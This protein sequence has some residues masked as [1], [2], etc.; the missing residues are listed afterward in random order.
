MTTPGSNEFGSV[1][2]TLKTEGKD[3]VV[4]DLKQVEQAAKQ[5]AEATNAAT[6]SPAS[7]AGSAANTA[8]KTAATAEATRTLASETERVA[9]N[10]RAAASAQEDFARQARDATK[11]IEFMQSMLGRVTAALSIGGAAIAGVWSLITKQQREAEAAFR[12]MSARA[13]E[14]EKITREIYGDNRNSLDRQLDALDRRQELE[15]KAY[16]RRDQAAKLEELRERYRDERAAIIRRAEDA[17]AIKAAQERARVYESELEKTQKAES[18]ARTEG[19]TEEE[20]VQDR[21]AQR[22]L[23]I[24]RKLSS[25]QDAMMRELL[26]RQLAAEEALAAKRLDSLAEKRAKEAEALAERQR[27]EEEAIQKSAAAFSEAF[28]KESQNAA[29]AAARAFE[30]SDVV[31][32]L[33]DISTLLRA[34]LQRRR[35]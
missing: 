11:P 15:E 34:N 13:A 9:K 10:A 20:A 5:T 23:E 12:E 29:E 25:E 3:T 2:V 6:A 24:S 14:V 4:S 35:L 22:R 17:E 7:P 32:R 26:E 27:K 30:N 33:Q 31:S 8:A 19:M 21:L 1:S 28:T 18:D 16:Q